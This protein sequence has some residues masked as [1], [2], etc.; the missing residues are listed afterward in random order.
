MFSTTLKPIYSSWYDSKLEYDVLRR[1]FMQIL[2]R[3]IKCDPQK[4]E[5][6]VPN[7]AKIILRNQMWNIGTKLEII[8]TIVSNM[9]MLCVSK[10]AEW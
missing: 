4:N 1:F 7:V 3:M 6:R 9:R 5:S 8:L 10:H 2:V